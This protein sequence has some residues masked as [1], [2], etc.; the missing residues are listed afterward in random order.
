[1]KLLY[2]VG[3]STNPEKAKIMTEKI[4]KHVISANLIQK[5]TGIQK[6]ELEFSDDTS[7]ED[8]LNLGALLGFMDATN[9]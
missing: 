5:E 4:A 8:I 6:I 7:K 3:I 1:M 2:H 9:F